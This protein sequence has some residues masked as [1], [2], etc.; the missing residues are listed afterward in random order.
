[1][2]ELMTAGYINDLRFSENYLTKRMHKGYGPKR[3][4]AELKARG[5]S[6]Q[7]IAE[8]IKITDNIWF[9]AAEKIWRKHFRHHSQ[10]KSNNQLNSTNDDAHYTPHP[11]LS[12]KEKPFYQ[13]NDLKKAYL[14]QKAKQIRF[15]QYRGFLEEHID[16]II[17]HYEE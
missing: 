7:M 3:I 5:I 13:K 12:N 10:F 11:L 6:S 2:K 17:N 14:K 8:L 16:A 15:L 4:S 1:M 9:L